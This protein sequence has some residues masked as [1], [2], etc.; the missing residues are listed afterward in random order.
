MRLAQRTQMELLGAVPIFS[1]CSKR[2][3]ATVA[4]T[5]PSGLLSISAHSF[6]DLLLRSPKLQYKLLEALA[7]RLAA[8]T[9]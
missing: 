7:E 6:H 3:V 4:R 1:P 8:L 2:D 5:A 9:T